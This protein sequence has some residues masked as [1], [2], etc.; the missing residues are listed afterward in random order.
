MIIYD[1]V[2]VYVIIS[3]CIHLYIDIHSEFAGVV[4]M[5]LS[6]GNGTG[7]HGQ[8]KPTDLPGPA[9]MGQSFAPARQARTGNDSSELPHEAART[10]T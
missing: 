7:L 10:V 1:H 3:E 8:G 4:Q 2:E 6:G 5:I 9:Q